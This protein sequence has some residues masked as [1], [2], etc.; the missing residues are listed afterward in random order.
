MPATSSAPSI[1]LSEYAAR[2]DRVLKDL[3]GA[4][5]I[6]FAGE[7][8]ASLHS[9]W[10]PHPHFEYLTGIADE[11]GAALLLDPNNPV[12]SR[13]AILFLRPL[14]PELE[15]WDGFRETISTALRERYGIGTVMRT[16][17]MPRFV[18]D[19]AVRAKR[20]ACLHPLAAYN[21]PV[22]PDLAFLRGVAERIPGCAI[23]DRSTLLASM[24]ARKSP[25]EVAVMRRAVEITARGYEAVIGAIRPGASEFDVQ[26]AIEHGYRTNGA[27]ATA[28][29]TIAGSGFNATVLHYHANDQPLRAGQLI[30][31]DSGAA[32]AGYSADITRTYPV[33]GRFT[34]R[35]RELYDVVLASQLAGIRAAKAGA[36]LMDIDKACRAVIV[37]AGYG[38]AFIHGSGHHLGLETHDV[39]PDEPLAP[40]AVITIEPGIYLP[41][42]SIGIRIEDDILVGKGS[43]TV[44]S[45]MIPKTAPEIERLFA[46]ARAS[47]RESA[48]PTTARRAR[49]RRR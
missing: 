39:S 46:S 43:P 44:L 35:Q 10:R 23:E 3:R 36:T 29:R 37:K 49:T 4:V 13:R 42:E 6:L 40:G 48:T 47:A 20:L 11:A 38:D 19:A 31:I 25:A 30:C 21:Q 14:N 26:E 5:G 17:S 1:P 8:S 32:Y 45:S 7:Q 24:R 27:R 9:E 15:K 18:T 2:R 22:S 16:L 12:A 41:E 34:P 28:Y 33:D